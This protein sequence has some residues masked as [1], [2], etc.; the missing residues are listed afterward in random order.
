MPRNSF[1]VLTFVL[2]VL[3]A[4]PVFCQLEEEVRVDLIEVWAKVTD[5]DNKV[6][7]DLK[8]EE[9]SIYI[10]GKK[11]E[12]RCFDTVFDEAPALAENEN[13]FQSASDDPRRVKRSFVFFFDLLH[14][15]SRDLD[16]LKNKISNFLESSF[17]EQ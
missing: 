3:L 5:K 11:M 9:F 6:V 10:D 8:P 4:P 7:K 17:H 16:F 14:T 2:A 1:L 13:T 15:S 12:M